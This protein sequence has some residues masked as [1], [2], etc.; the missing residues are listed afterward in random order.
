MSPRAKELFEA[1]RDHI[2]RRTDR[3]FAGLMLFQF[4]GGLIAALVISPRAWSGAMSQVHLHVWAALLLGGL[5]ASLPIALAL[6]VPG[7]FITRCVIATAQMLFSA[8]LIHLTGGRIETHFHVFGSLAV[9]AFYRDWRV[10]IPATL[11]VGLDHL[12]RGIYWPESVYGVLTA[13]PWRSLEHAGWVIFE[14][15]FLIRSCFQS[16]REM[17]D[18]A[19]KRAQLEGTNA[20]VEQ[21]VRQRT[22]ELV[23]RTAALQQE[24]AER[25]RV[26]Q[27]LREMNMALANAMPG[28]SKLDSQG[29]YVQVND[30]YAEMIGYR[31]EE[32]IGMSW[33][34]TVHPDDH[35]AAV[36]AYQRMLRTGIAEL[37]ARAVRKDGSQFFKLVMMV[38]ISAPDGQT[39]GHHCFMRDISERRRAEAERD[40]LHRQLLEV[41]RRAGMAEVATGVLHNVGNVLNSVNVSVTLVAEK[42]R[43]SEAPDLVKIADLLNRADDLGQFITSDSKGKL[44][45]QFLA[46]LG[47]QLVAEQTVMLT[48]LQS[49]TKNVEHIKDIVTMQ[50]SYARVSGVTESVNLA[51]LVEDAVRIN[52]AALQR[53][54]IELVRDYEDIPPVV[55]DKQKVLQV[56]VNLI[57]NAKYAI[58]DGGK[59]Q[60]VLTIRVAATGDETGRARIEVRDNGIGIP[61]ENLTRIFSHGFTTRKHGHGFGLHSCSL[62]AKE[63]GGCLRAHSDGPGKGATFT[64]ELPLATAN[65]D[66]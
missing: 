18:I 39:L 51:Q 22:A 60:R 26:E 63:M 25:E 57:N 11:V 5:I 12:I 32:L 3:L 31:P 6:L 19:A 46:G 24:V 48:E 34:K 65:A 7:R 30:V 10:F 9:L 40:D 43:K 59:P 61:P 16:I 49:L 47:A 21:Q 44:I 50:Q 15:I 38:K 20:I 33:E 23:Q 58:S 8:L 41:S 52:S 54:G 55:L 37:E 29:R 14:D 2:L 13:S 42:V 36:Q 53:H 4:V 27:A 66:L 45:P 17:R 35:R 62:T 28:I 1:H 56:L 64:L